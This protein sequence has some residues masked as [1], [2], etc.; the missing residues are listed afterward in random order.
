MEA[1]CSPALL[2]NAEQ[3]L[4]ADCSIVREG[5]ADWSWLWGGCDPGFH[6]CNGIFCCQDF[7]YVPPEQRILSTI[8]AHRGTPWAWGGCSWAYGMDCSCFVQTVFREA[9]GVHL[10]RTVEQQWDA[11]KSVWQMNLRP[12]D[13][14]FFNFSWA[15]WFQKPTHVGIYVGV[16]NG[17]ESFAH[18]SKSH[19]V[20]FAPVNSEYWSSNYKGARR[21]LEQ[22]GWW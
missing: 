1:T 3:V 18:A 13:L 15:S 4:A 22:P 11:G 19:G 8:Q 10:P 9:V 17:V 21:V 20:S 14:V 16:H 7:G 5:K 12:G 6:R 2:E